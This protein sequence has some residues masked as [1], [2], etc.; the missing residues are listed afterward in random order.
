MKNIL[1]QI[2]QELSLGIIFV[3]EAR[4]QNKQLISKY[5]Y[6][7]NLQMSCQEFKNDG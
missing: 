7:M 5:Q 3:V 4:K 6:L 1:H 2:C